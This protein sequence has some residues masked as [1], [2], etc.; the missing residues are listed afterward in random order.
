MLLLRKWRPQLSGKPDHVREMP[1]TTAPLA[2]EFDVFLFAP[3]GE[4]RNGAPLSVLSALARLNVDPWEEAAALAR[5]PLDAATRKLTSLIAALPVGS[6][7]RADP[8]TM[9]QRLVVLLRS[10]PA[11]QIR[12]RAAVPRGASIRFQAIA[13]AM[14]F[15]IAM[16]FMIT[17]HWIMAARHTQMSLEKSLAPVVVTVFRQT[18]PPHYDD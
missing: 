5:L 18:M 15:L 17:S 10:Q 3:M 16:V 8:V 9:A 13:V 6:S 1:H 12:S 2:S 14:C 11:L 7:A 4:D